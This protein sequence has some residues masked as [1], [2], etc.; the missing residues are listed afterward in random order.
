MDAVGEKVLEKI[1]FRPNKGNKKIF[2]FKSVN[3]HFYLNDKSFIFALFYV[4][5]YRMLDICVA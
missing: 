4:L 3:W 2:M 5:V 1:R